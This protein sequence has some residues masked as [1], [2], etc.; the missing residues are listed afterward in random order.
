MMGWFDHDWNR[1]WFRGRCRYKTDRQKQFQGKAKRHDCSEQ[2]IN[3]S[4]QSGL[5]VVQYKP[6]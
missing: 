2:D 5:P 1:M 6:K 3:R 4:Q